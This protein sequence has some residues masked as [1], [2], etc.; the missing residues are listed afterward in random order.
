MA[1]GLSEKTPNCGKIINNRLNRGIFCRRRLP[2]EAQRCV[3]CQSA[4]NI[5]HFS[6]LLRAFFTLLESVGVVAGFKDVA[7]MGKAIKQGGCRR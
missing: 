2:A 6:S 5:F 4:S 7:V 1:A 3:G